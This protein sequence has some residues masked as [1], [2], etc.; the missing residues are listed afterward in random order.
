MPWCFL[1]NNADLA[2]TFPVDLTD[3]GRTAIEIPYAAKGAHAALGGCGNGN[4]WPHPIFSVCDNLI[5][6]TFAWNGDNLAL[7]FF[8]HHQTACFAFGC[9]FNGCAFGA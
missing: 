5:L 4:I 7:D 8:A 9:E 3:F 2:W 6:A 1:K